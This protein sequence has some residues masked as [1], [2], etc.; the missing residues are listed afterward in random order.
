MPNQHFQWSSSTQAERDTGPEPGVRQPQ[1]IHQPHHKTVAA[2]KTEHK[3]SC[4]KNLGLLHTR[5][6]IGTNHHYHLTVCIA[7]SFQVK[8]IFKA[9]KTLKFF[10]F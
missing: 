4:T 8:T 9:K 7:F 1:K 10:C 5:R 2:D 6:Y 3:A